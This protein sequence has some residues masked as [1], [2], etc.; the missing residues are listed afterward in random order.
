MASPVSLKRGGPRA[1]ARSGSSLF[2]SR[3]WDRSVTCSISKTKCPRQQ[4]LRCIIKRIP[5]QSLSC[6]TPECNL[7]LQ[8][9]KTQ[10]HHCR[11]DKKSLVNLRWNERLELLSTCINITD[12]RHIFAAVAFSSDEQRPMLQLLVLCKE[13]LE[14]NVEVCCI[15]KLFCGDAS[16][17]CDLNL[18]NGNTRRMVY[19]SPKECCPRCVCQ[20]HRAIC[21]CCQDCSS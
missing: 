21:I 19:A 1:V 11:A 15:L 18:S 7:S 9:Y 3:A 17:A 10:C 12:C 8:I 13:S 16:L 5:S 6:N 14:G 2:R 20:A 4:R